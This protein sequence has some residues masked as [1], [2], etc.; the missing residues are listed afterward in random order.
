MSRDR[1]T[2]SSARVRILG[3]YVVLLGVAL[4][5]ALFLQRAFLLAQAEADAERALDQEV[6]ELRQLAGGID[7]VTG[8]PFGGDVEAI[9]DTFLSRNVPLEGEGLLTYVSGTIYKTD[10]L[11]SRIAGLPVA[12]GWGSV[13]ESERGVLEET[14]LGPIRYLAVPLIAEQEE[15]GVFVVAVLMENRLDRVDGVVRLGALV[16]GSIFLLASALAWVAAGRILRPLRA[17]ADTAGS[18]A[19]TEDLS[20]RIDVEG[21]DEISELGR[22]FNAMLDRLDDA[23]AAQRRFIDDAGHELRTPITIIR[24]NLEVMDDDPDERE[25]TVALVTDE[26]DRMSR[27]VD[28]LL[29]LAKA[30][31]PDFIQAGPV[32]LAE[33]IRELAS[34]AEVLDDRPWN[35]EQTEHAVIVA[36]RHRLNQAMMNLIRNAAEHS[37]AGTPVH[38][39]STIE[40]GEVRLW[41]RDE[42]EPI[43]EDRRDQIFDR[44]SRVQSGRRSTDGAGLGLAIVKAIAEAHGGAVSVTSPAAGG[45]VFTITLPTEPFPGDRP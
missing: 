29:D 43:A 1:A 3:W 5:A 21:D 45:N 37:P 17:L 39:G 42:G 33:T 32:D 4:I 19:E 44:F 31:Q 25:E 12:D 20:R 8:E 26:L 6:G 22:T 34:K 2:S 28:D 10:V 40:N 38:I 15:A 18:I 24:G 35:V 27:I 9:F 11:G 16:Y 14:D 13:T 41:V 36:D 30:D 23:F 7:P